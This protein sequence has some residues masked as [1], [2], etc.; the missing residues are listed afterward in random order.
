MQ[1]S[2]VTRTL[3][4][5]SLIL[6]AAGAALAVGGAAYY[7]TH[8]Q[9]VAATLPTTMEPYAH[10]VTLTATDGASLYATWIPGRRADGRPGSPRQA[11]KRPESDRSLS[12]LLPNPIFEVSIE[13]LGR[14]GR[15]PRPPRWFS[16][17]G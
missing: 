2:T 1:V 6:Q 12:S 11:K 7:F 15:R 4:R 16:R 8:P 5:R 9:R 3:L 13:G 10:G 17:S 14:G